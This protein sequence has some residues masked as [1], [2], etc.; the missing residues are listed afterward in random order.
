MMA[1]GQCVGV[2]AMGQSLYIGRRLCIRLRA[3]II[4][5][6]FAK[7]LRRQ[8]TTGN[9][10]KAKTDKQ[11]QPTVDNETAA[12]EGKIANL[13]S[14]D[15]FQISEICAYIFYLW[16]C[17]FAVVINS[18]LLYNTLGLASLAGI[19]VLVLLIPVQALIGRLYTV[20]QRK[21]MAATDAR[22]ES[23][24]EVIAH[25][26]LI[27]FNAWESK[28]IERMA[29]TRK[30]E[31][32]IL[33]QRFATTVLS[34]LVIWG[35]P[36]LVTASAFA[37][38]S[39]VLK[40]PLTADRAFS[41]LILFN[42]LRDPMG[43]FQDTLT[44]LLQSYTSCTRI[45]AFLDEPDTLKYRQLTRPGPADPG[46][47]FDDA[48]VG[49]STAA[50]MQDAEFEPFR[51]GPLDLS[52]PVGQ[53]SVIAGPVG[54]GKTT[55]IAS[56]LGETTLLQ[57]KIFM[58]DDHAN[59]DVC[60]VDPVTGL[61][62]TV[63]YCAQTSWLVGASIRENIVFGA[64]WDKKRYDS[65]V[66]ACAL[67]RDFEIF[68]M[69][70][71]TEVGEKGTTCS[72]GQKARI[73]L[74]R[75]VY[76][77]A[78]TVILDDVLSAV[79][80]QTARHLHD[81]VLTGPIMRGRTC[82][83][84]S[85]A[86]NLVAP[87]AAFVVLLDGGNVIAS[88]SP[89]ELSASGAL[90]LADSEGS[91]ENDAGESVDGEVDQDSEVAPSASTIA[92]TVLSAP[93]D[94]A[95]GDLEGLEAEPLET[96]KPVTT[97]PAVSKQ[98]VQNEAQSSGAVGIA[99]YLLYFKAQGGIF[100]WT[101][102][103]TAFAGS[104]FL[105]VGTN[106]WI[107]EWANSNDKKAQLSSRVSAFVVQQA[108]RVV[109]LAQE[110]RSTQFWLSVY[111]GIAGLYL[112][113]VAMRVGVNFYGSLCAS[114]GLYDRLLKRILGA[115]MRWVGW[116]ESNADGQVFRLDP[117]VCERLGRANVSGRIMNRLSKDIASVDTEA[118]E[119]EWLGRGNALRPQSCSTL[120]NASCLSSP[121]FSS[122]S[123][124]RLVSWVRE[125]GLTISIHLYLG[126]Y[127]RPVLDRRGA[128]RRDESGDQ[129]I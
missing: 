119:S 3:V 17:P 53:L 78:K 13:V 15:A 114:K 45:Q 11:G 111:C 2:V 59:R 104:Q 66:H 26:K 21:F 69:G 113:A 55:L 121:S 54:S 35:T 9:V 39:L 20:I 84:V 7:A 85:H 44:R 91:T 10:T 123:F 22:L 29:A 65:V 102:V 33:A 98:L 115:R 28:F 70:D 27:K 62:D 122:S 86:I 57:G 48:V 23:V 81:H 30:T 112:V 129:A 68:D 82:I 96:G 100:Y 95:D 105:Q 41:S 37:V 75:A 87:S 4:A 18:I 83:L 46:V 92:A 90:D 38:H 34:N 128:V 25:V 77:S 99:T 120:P 64:T 16:S 74:A 93:K 79:D 80:A 72:G 60:P 67:R 117:F 5:E 47:G 32:A 126:H 6:V 8:D 58:P 36:V 107:Q 61:S 73:A 109:R 31:L 125:E 110:E 40:Q 106:K 14:V 116:D 88:G 24:T 50:E 52:F 108:G 63:A 12:S 103:L 71:E 1:I 94:M 49:Y 19:A 97:E 89:A 56:L 124:P 43:L 51:L 76:S 42:M 127:R 118:A 101:L